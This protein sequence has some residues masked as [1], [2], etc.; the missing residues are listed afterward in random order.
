MHV[1]VRSQRGDGKEAL[2]VAI[3][4]GLGQGPL[5]PG[6]QCMRVSAV[7]GCL[8][9]P[10]VL[11]CRKAHPDVSPEVLGSQIYLGRLGESRREV[12]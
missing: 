5:A 6:R 8:R 3:P 11:G 12:P 4:V 2:V 9:K 1:V 10:A 7:T